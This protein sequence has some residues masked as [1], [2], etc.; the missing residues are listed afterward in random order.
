MLAYAV[1][2]KGIRDDGYN[3]GW[4]VTPLGEKLKDKYVRHYPDE[5]YEWYKNDKFNR[6]RSSK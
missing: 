4:E 2:D 3:L 6:R 1:R 5:Y